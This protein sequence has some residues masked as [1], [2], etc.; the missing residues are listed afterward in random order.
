MIRTTM[1][2]PELYRALHGKRICG[3]CTP[4]AHRR[5]IAQLVLI[6]ACSS[7]AVPGFAQQRAGVPTPVSRRAPGGELGASARQHFD[8]AM[9]HYR[10]RSYREAIH[11]FELSNARVPSADVWFNIGRAHEQL[12]E[13]RL[14]VE[15]YRRYLRERTDAPDARELRAHIDELTRRGEVSPDSPQRRA[16][17]G[18]LAIDA[19]QAGALVMLD[20]KRLDIAPIDKILQVSPGLHRLEVSREGYIPFRAAIDVQPGAL[21]AA[22]VDLRPLTQPPPAKGTSLW[23]WLAVGA[24]GAALITGTALGAVALD[25]RD[26]GDLD[27][28]NDLARASDIALGSAL[29]LAVGAAILHFSSGDH[30]ADTP[31]RHAESAWLPHGRVP[32]RNARRHGTVRSVW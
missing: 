13:L 25:R 32:G 21:S 12:G 30:V 27:A 15:S 24:S 4:R 6:V 28:A 31:P 20:G 9:A 11:E 5:S 16:E 19:D 10:A 23:T 18:S 7:A 17:H 14:A 2:K 26:D 3:Q 1:T 29:A 22:Y 8:A